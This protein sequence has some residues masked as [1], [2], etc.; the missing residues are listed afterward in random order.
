MLAAHVAPMGANICTAMAIRT[1][2]RNFRNR[3]RINEPTFFRHDQ[4]I[5]HRVSS[6]D[7]VPGDEALRT[8]AGFRTPNFREQQ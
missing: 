6:R 4:L 8:I 1:I 7:Q 3:R 2:G 5:M